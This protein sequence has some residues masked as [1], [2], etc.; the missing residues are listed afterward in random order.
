MTQHKVHGWN[1]VGHALAGTGP[2]RQH[3]R[4]PTARDANGVGLMPMPPERVAG[5]CGFG[6]DPKDRAA[7]GGQQTF[8]RELIDE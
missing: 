1:D 6:P 3:I 2:G 4:M 7:F 8:A 5:N